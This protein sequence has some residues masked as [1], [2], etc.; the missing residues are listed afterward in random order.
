MIKKEYLQP[1]LEITQAEVEQL[2]AVSVTRAQT[3]GLDQGEKI[4]VQKETP[5]NYNVWDDAW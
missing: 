2:V 5:K 4:D 3:T 1:A